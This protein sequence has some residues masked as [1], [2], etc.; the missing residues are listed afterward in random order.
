M[1]GRVDVCSSKGFNRPRWGMGFA[2]ITRMQ[3]HLILVEREAIRLPGLTP[4]HT[5]AA[6]A[7]AALEPGTVAG[8]PAKSWLRPTF[9]TWR[10]PSSI[11]PKLLLRNVL[12]S[13]EGA[14]RSLKRNTGARRGKRPFSYLGPA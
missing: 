11:A 2:M 13:N 14:P 5:P 9:P 10:G 7:F 6:S 4:C 12:N 8:L 3:T 1:G